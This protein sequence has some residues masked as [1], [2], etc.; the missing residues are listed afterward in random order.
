MAYKKILYEYFL[1]S[2]QEEQEFRAML[3]DT[4]FF[5]EYMGYTD[6]QES[7]GCYHFWVAATV[8]ATVT[9]RRCYISKGIYR[10]YPNLYVILVAPSGRCRKTRACSL[11]TGLI[12][13]WPWTNIIADKTTPEALLVALESGTQNMTNGNSG[14]TESRGMSGADGRI[15]CSG[16]VK[17]PEL[18]VF[19][20]QQTYTTGIVPLL[21][22][23]Y[24][25]PDDFKYIT[26]TKKP[27]VLKN[28]FVNLLAG[29]T[30]EWL[31]TALPEYAF[32]GGF[33]SRI[34]FV[35]KT[36]RDRNFPFPTEPHPDE[37][38]RL[39]E[40]LMLIRKNM[41]GEMKISQ[42]AM[43]WYDIWYRDI[44]SMAVEDEAMLGFVERKPDT[45]LKVAHLLV[46]A[47]MRKQIELSDIR[48][49][50]MIV[51]W[52][53]N[54]M[55]D[56]FS[57]VDMT[58]L[59]AVTRK[60]LQLIESRGTISR[61]EVL[62]KL[63]HKLPQGISDL[64]RIEELLIQQHY[65]RK[66]ERGGTGGRPAIRYTSLRGRKQPEDWWKGGDD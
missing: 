48:R 36:I 12:D 63:A 59:G 51:S 42:K 2:Q 7:P 41:T 18:S 17:A 33:M 53:Q 27:V 26:R 30:P 8:L 22:H 16:L 11:G 55:F 37:L 43:E 52:T 14:G 57:D 45:V 61:R 10:L 34:V 20:N 40:T 54:R 19:M 47:E 65:I 28:L 24:D 15:V 23:L 6:R 13:K 29:S 35:V 38:K 31:A 21:T 46:L 1:Q 56:A 32:E 25:C 4:G 64:Q 5:S 50:M 62:R 39:R 60:V 49:A 44:S 3:P 66:D 58:T 9:D